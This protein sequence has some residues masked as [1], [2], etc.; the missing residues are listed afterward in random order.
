MRWD[1]EG[2]QAAEPEVARFLAELAQAMDDR[3]TR[4]R[5]AH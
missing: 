4:Y 2:Q 5:G 1:A 3:V